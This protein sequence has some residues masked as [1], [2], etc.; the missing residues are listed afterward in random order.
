MACDRRIIFRVS[1]H[2]RA[3]AR[4]PDIGRLC[5]DACGRFASVSAGWRALSIVPSMR[6]PALGHRAV[7]AVEFREFGGLPDTASRFVVPD[8]VIFTIPISLA[9]FL[10]DASAAG[11]GCWS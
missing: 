9:A 4:M 6:F 10:L 2:W 11:P 8:P 1:A 3:A 5:D 7:H